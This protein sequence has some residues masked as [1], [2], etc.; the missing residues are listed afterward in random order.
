MV[1][2]CRGCQKFTASAYSLTT[3]FPRESVS[4]TGDLIRGGLGAGGKDHYFCQSC[5]NFIYSQIAGAEDRINLRTSVL[6]D[7][8][9]FEPF[10][11]VMTDEKMS[12]ATVPVRHS[13]ARTPA[14]PEELLALM[15]DYKNR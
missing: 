7:A 12:W 1:C 11:E 8:T 4:C 6:D 15:T 14:S 5:L 9:Y 10:V 13:Y 2:H 3:M